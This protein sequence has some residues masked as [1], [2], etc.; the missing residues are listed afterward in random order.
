MYKIISTLKLGFILGICCFWSIHLLA[1]EEKSEKNEKFPSYFGLQFKPLIAGNFL[2]SSQLKLREGNFSATVN[3]TFGYTFGASV[4]IG[5]TKLI[6]LETGLNQVQRNYSIDFSIPDSNLNA[7]NTIGFMNYDIP[8]NALIYIQLGKNLFMNT[9]MGGSMVYN[10]TDVASKI[11]LEKGN[12]FNFEGRRFSKIGFEM[13]ANI[14]MELRTS[15]SGIFYLGASGRIPIKPIY[16]VA[17]VYERQDHTQVAIGNLIGTYVAFDIRYYFPNIKNKGEQFIP[18][19]I[20][21]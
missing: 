9:S 8:F 6:S 10:P 7:K 2:G 21:Q 4:R 20:D 13:N 11:A 19:P 3:Q 16:Q 15:K 17:A 5:L 14:G 12:V 1:Q 18:G